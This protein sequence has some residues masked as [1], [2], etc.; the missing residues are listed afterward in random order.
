M[1]IVSLA[2]GVAVGAAAGG[3]GTYLLA[4]RLKPSKIEKP[5]VEVA[6]SRSVDETEVKRAR[7]ELKTLLL[8]KE[9]LAGALTRVY[10]AEAEGKITKEEREVL[11]SKYKEQLKSVEG[12]LGDLE[13]VIEVGELE[14]LRTELV[15]LLQ[16]KIAQIEER[17]HE[18]KVKLGR[19][20]AEPRPEA[21]P[22]EKREEKVEKRR[23]EAGEVE[24]DE[25]VR[26]L[27]EE[28]LEALARLEQMD[29]E[30]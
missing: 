5:N 23:P 30:G 28:V 17:L 29:I 18:A 2:L 20:R 13:L 24:V 21:P 7:K 15:G 4:R 16:K 11:A 12:K 22:I 25:R 3:S 1:E 6:R 19:I 26:A 27:R 14:N 8:E 9:L 10:E